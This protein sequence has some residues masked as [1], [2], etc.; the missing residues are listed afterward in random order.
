[1]GSNAIAAGDLGRRLRPPEVEALFERLAAR[2]VPKSELNWTTPLDLLVAV[3]LSA[4]TTD[5]AVNQVTA[6]LWQ[7]CRTPQDY[8][9]LGEERLAGQ[10]RHI[11]LFRNKARSVIGICTRLLALHGG[12]V[13]AR[14]EDL[15]ALPGVGRKTAS[16]V[17]NV[18]FGQPAIAVDTHV[19]RVAQRTGLARAATPDE[20]A[21][22]LMQCVP[23]R[24]LGDA[25]HYL[26]L[27]GRYTCTARQPRCA[28]CP[29]AALC[30]YRRKRLPANG[31]PA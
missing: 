23:E 7:T 27:H 6:E 16:V 10:L 9:D 20:M 13:P 17:L 8:L 22:R 11:G 26:I 4:Q 2:I 30:T 25:H 19:F 15:E 31:D 5:K 21:E 29:V 18:A 24:F 14:R 1:M 28:D 12:D 3:V